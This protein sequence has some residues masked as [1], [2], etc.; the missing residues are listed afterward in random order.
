[1][2]GQDNFGGYDLTGV[3]VAAAIVNHLAIHH[4]YGRPAPRTDPVVALR[5]LLDV[6]PPSV[7]ELADDHVPGFVALAA[8]LR[9]VF[10]DLDRGDL[11]AAARRLNVL[12]TAHPAHPHLAQEEGR[13]RL[14]HHPADADLV[15]MWTAI[16]AEGMARVIGAGDHRRLGTCGSDGCDRVFL[17]CSKNASRRFCST[18]CQN[19]VKA[20]SFRRRRRDGAARSPEPGDG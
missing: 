9:D 8:R 11:D 1:V 4:A 7:A 19:R 3:A 2:T 13:W 14:H 6:D 15:P 18:T 5:E 12:L 17:D 10:D 20:A 16:C